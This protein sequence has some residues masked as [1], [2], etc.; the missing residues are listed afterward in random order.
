MNFPV[1]GHSQTSA[2]KYQLALYAQQNPFA[3]Q[4]MAPLLGPLFNQD[5]LLR[6]AGNQSWQMPQQYQSPSSYMPLPNIQFSGAPA[7]QGLN[8]NPGGG[9]PENS[10]QTAG[11]YTIVPEGNASWKIFDKGAKPGDAAMTHVWGDPHVN[12]K[13]GTRWDFTKDSNF[14]LPDGT[15]IAVHTSS[16]TGQSVTTADLP[17]PWPSMA[18]FTNSTICDSAQ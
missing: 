1:N 5:A 10:I 17:M 4:A 8:K 13:D 9:W 7:G 11:G 12:E 15:T 18:R 6:G 16:E 3:A 14:R 2:W